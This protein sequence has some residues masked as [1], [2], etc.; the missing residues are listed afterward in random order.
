MA[1]NRTV[2]MSLNYF[3]KKHSLTGH[4]FAFHHHLDFW[5]KIVVSETERQPAIIVTNFMVASVTNHHDDTQNDV[6]IQGLAEE[7][8]Q[9][10]GLLDCMQHLIYL[11]IHA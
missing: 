6:A 8:E 11:W 7:E 9:L 5:S 10:F 2:N 1:Q 3:Q 4:G